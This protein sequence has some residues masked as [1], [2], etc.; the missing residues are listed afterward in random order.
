MQSA[1]KKAEKFLEEFDFI[2]SLLSCEAEASS[3]AEA[4]AATLNFLNEK[5]I[6]I[7]WSNNFRALKTFYHMRNS[8]YHLPFWIL[9]VAKQRWI[10][11]AGGGKRKRKLL[12]ETV[13]TSLSQD[14]L[15][16]F[17][18][19]NFLN[20][21]ICIR[22]L[23][24]MVRFKKETALI[25]LYNDNNGSDHG[26]WKSARLLESVVRPNLLTDENINIAF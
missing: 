8:L 14:L 25:F 26:K 13:R 19:V 15:L 12:A 17:L 21:L 24:M 2:Q 1:T 9:V 20:E 5:L 16:F 11:D 23:I 22:K 3:G 7:L 10:L 18:S 4:G 6:P